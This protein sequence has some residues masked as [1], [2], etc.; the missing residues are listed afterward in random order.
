M[1]SSG[2][3]VNPPD[4]GGGRRKATAKRPKSGG[5]PNLLLLGGAQKQTFSGFTGNSTRMDKS[6][7]KKLYAAVDVYV[8]DFGELTAVPNRFMATRDVFVLQSDKW[9]ISY[10]RPFQMLDIAKAGDSEKR[11]LVGE[12]T[13]VAKAPTANTKL[14]NV[15]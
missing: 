14:T 3:R 7:D 8:S 1:R 11:M 4:E 5:K 9:A 13:L 2:S 6:E 15:T 12:Y 10:L